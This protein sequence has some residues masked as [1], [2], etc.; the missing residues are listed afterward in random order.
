[1]SA[2]ALRTQCL[3]VVLSTSLVVLSTSE[4]WQVFCLRQRNRDQSAVSVDSYR[5]ELQRHQEEIARL[6]KQKADEAKR[7]SDE[8]R[9]ANDAA[10]SAR[11]ST[12]SSTTQSYLRTVQRH[13]DA[14][15]GAQKK[16]A[17]I[18]Q[19]LAR[20]QNQV[21]Q[22]QRNLERAEEQ[23]RRT[24]NATEQRAQREREEKARRAEQ[25]R[26]R[27]LDGVRERLQDHQA[28]HVA[29]FSAIQ[30]LQEL[31]ETITVLFLAS[32]PLD[33]PSL[34]LDEEA[35]AIGEMIRLSAYRD[36]VKLQSRWAARPLDILQAIN[37]CKPRIVHFSGHGSMEGDLVFQDAAGATRLVSTAALVQTM[38]TDSDIQ[39]VFFNA[40]YTSIQAQEIV[41]HVSAAIGMSTAIGDDA[42]RIFAAQFYSAIGFGRSVAV[43]FRQA[44]AALMLEGIPEEDTPELY[45]SDGLDLESLVLVR[46]P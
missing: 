36:A 6:Q 41:R 33:Q 42:A 2:N 22:T 9:R 46:P 12:H 16:I 40:C 39:L 20:K 35:R 24:R 17:D 21:I 31:P 25:S 30:R 11:R 5:R 19:K 3:L 7:S 8:S 13:N 14:V 43:A 37:E 32:S 45:G 18:E 38:T 44:R 4:G 28:L 1:M 26:K 10:A 27:E 15:S 23:E 29:T 34:R